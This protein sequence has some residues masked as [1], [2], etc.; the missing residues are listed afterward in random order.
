ME[1]L[2]SDL[3]QVSNSSAE[4][5]KSHDLAIMAVSGL[6]AVALCF[7]IALYSNPSNIAPSDPVPISFY[8]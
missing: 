1:S 3:A 2:M 6:L 4:S 7:V 5:C 8:P